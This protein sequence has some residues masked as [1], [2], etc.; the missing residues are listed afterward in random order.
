MHGYGDPRNLIELLKKEFSNPR[1][2]IIVFGHSHMPMNECIEGVLFFNPGSPTDTAFAPYK[3]Y[4]IIEIKDDKIE[5]QI[6]KIE[7]E[8]T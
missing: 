8:R 2:D 3:S 4:G 5:A 6:Y 7:V 1:P